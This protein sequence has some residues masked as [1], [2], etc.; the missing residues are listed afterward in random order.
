MVFL[1][2]VQNPPPLPSH[3]FLSRYLRVERVCVAAADIQ[4]TRTPGLRPPSQAGV[5]Q[6]TVV[7]VVMVA[8]AAAGQIDA[9]LGRV[10]PGQGELREKHAESPTI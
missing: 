6:V 7:V 8:T 10:G 5:F 1:Y 4:I 9:R 2:T 3:S